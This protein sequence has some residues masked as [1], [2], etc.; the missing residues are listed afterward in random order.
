MLHV[1]MYTH[2]THKENTTIENVIL[3]DKNIF[4]LLSVDKECESTV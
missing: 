3:I 4:V 2:C 1:V